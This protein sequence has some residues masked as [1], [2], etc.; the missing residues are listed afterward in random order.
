MHEQITKKKITKENF[1][2]E[3]FE[4][5]EIEQCLKGVKL[6]GDDFSEEQVQDWFEDEKDGY[7]GLTESEAS[8]YFMDIM[9]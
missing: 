9:R 4:K 5:L 3:S 2:K 7:F 6:Y 8:N 1:K